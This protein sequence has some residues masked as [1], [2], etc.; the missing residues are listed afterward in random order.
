M[1][2]SIKILFSTNGTGILIFLRRLRRY[3][4]CQR[5]KIMMCSCACALN[6]QIEVL[7]QGL[8]L[9]IRQRAVTICTFL[10]GVFF[11]GRA[12]TRSIISLLFVRNESVLYSRLILSCPSHLFD[13]ITAGLN[14]GFRADLDVETTIDGILTAS[15]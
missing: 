14:R 5:Q 7:S 11:N 9:Q 13:T 4:R 12:I 10:L 6:H 3:A 15:K 8:S 2:D 1:Y